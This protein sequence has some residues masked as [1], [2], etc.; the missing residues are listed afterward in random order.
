MPMK[1][2]EQDMQEL[3]E[4]HKRDGLGEFR[5]VR[6]PA[7]SLMLTVGNKVWEA[8][9]GCNVS[10]PETEEARAQFGTR[11]MFHPTKEHLEWVNPTPEERATLAFLDAPIF[12]S[13]EPRKRGFFGRRRRP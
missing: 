7:M 3:M 11:G 12:P 5:E 8:P 6:D 1:G 2:S 9:C 10:V 13:P 4:R